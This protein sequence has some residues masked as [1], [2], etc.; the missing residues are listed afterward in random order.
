MIR[1]VLC[2][3]AEA[4][5]ILAPAKSHKTDSGDLFNLGELLDQGTAYK[6]I[7]PD[8]P[9]VAA[10]V[11]MPCGSTLWITAAAGRAAFDLVGVISALVINQAGEF[12]H[13]GFRT[14]R[15]GL[16]R[17]A[18]RLGYQVTRREGR[19]YFLRKNIGP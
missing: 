16:V 12:D 11:L 17:K 4:E 10:Y 13:V 7:A 8:G 9:T 15:A 6:V 19:A 18:L 2:D 1:A 5:V 3:A 14:E